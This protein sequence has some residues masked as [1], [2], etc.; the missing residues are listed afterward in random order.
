[1]FYPATFYSISIFRYRIMSNKQI[2]QFMETDK[3]EF[4]RRGVQ[5]KTCVQTAGD[6]DDDNDGDN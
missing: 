1:M 4:A 5:G 2:L 6:D 3:Q